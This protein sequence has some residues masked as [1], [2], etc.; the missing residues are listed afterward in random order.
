MLKIMKKSQ[1]C[2]HLENNFIDFDKIV[3]FFLQLFLESSE[4]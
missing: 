4:T 1:I 2:S 3:I